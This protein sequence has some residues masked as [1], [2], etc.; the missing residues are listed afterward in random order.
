MMAVVDT[1]VGAIVSIGF[2]ILAN[3]PGEFFATN[4]QIKPAKAPL[5]LLVGA[6]DKADLFRGAVAPTIFVDSGDNSKF[7]AGANGDVVSAGPGANKEVF[8]PEDDTGTTIVV[9]PGS[10]TIIGGTSKDQLVVLVDRLWTSATGIPIAGST[11]PLSPT[12]RLTGG[13]R[14]T[15]EAITGSDGESYKI[16]NTWYGAE[17]TT[18]GVNVTYSMR[19][20]GDL[21]IDIEAEAPRY[22]GP[23]IT[24]ALANAATSSHRE[25]WTAKLL[26]KNFHPGDFGL[27]FSA[28]ASAASPD[29]GFRTAQDDGAGSPAPARAPSINDDPSVPWNGKFANGPAPFPNPSDAQLNA[30]LKALQNLYKDVPA[31]RSP[32]PVAQEISAKTDRHT[33]ITLPF[34]SNKSFS[35]AIVDGPSRGTATL[36]ADDTFTFDPGDG[37]SDLAAGASLTVTFSYQLTDIATRQRSNVATVTITVGNGATGEI[38]V[39]D[40]LRASASNQ[41]INESF[42]A[43]T[44]ANVAA[45]IDAIEAARGT[46]PIRLTD[47]ETPTLELTAK[48]AANDRYALRAITNQE[49]AI[50]VSDTAANVA[51]DLND[52]NAVRHLASISLIDGRTPTLVLTAAKTLG[53]KTALGKITNPAYAIAI[54]DRSSDIASNFEALVAND[55][56]TSISGAFGWHLTLT[57][58]ETL[59][60]ATLLATA[61]GKID[62]KDTAANV[63]AKSAL[64]AAS[65]LVASISVADAVGN[66]LSDLAALKKSSLRISISASGSAADILANAAALKGDATLIVVVDTAANVANNAKALSKIEPLPLIKVTDSAANVVKAI[67]VLNGIKQIGTITLTDPGTPT[68]TLTA[69]QLLGDRK[70]IHDIDNA[71]YDIV[72]SDIAENVSAN[73]DALNRDN[74]VASILLTDPG[75]PKLKLRVIQTLGDT[76]FRVDA[77]AKIKNPNYTVLVSDTGVAVAERIEALGRNAKISAI[78]LKDGATLMLPARDALADIK[79]LD[80]VSTPGFGIVIS[81]SVS[82][83]LANA[84]ALSSNKRLKSV[85]VTDNAANIVANYNA[86]RASPF[87]KSIIVDDNAKNILATQN[88]LVKEVNAIHIRDTVSALLADTAALQRLAAVKSV[89]VD[90]RLENVIA[91]LD[92][93]N[94]N[95]LITSIR[96][97]GRPVLELTAEQAAKN[98]RALA[99]MSEKTNIVVRDTAANFLANVDGLSTNDDISSITTTGFFQLTPTAQQALAGKRAFSKLVNSNYRI[100]VQ[101]TVANIVSYIKTHPERLSMGVSVAD[102][103]ANISA[104]LTSL[105]QHGLSSSSITAVDTAA[106]I[107]A[108]KAA[109][110]NEAGHIKIVDTAA[111]IVKNSEALN[112][113]T[114]PASVAVVDTAANVATHFEALKNNPQVAAITLTDPG[115]PIL[116]LSEKQ[117]TDDAATINNITNDKLI[118]GTAGSTHAI[119]VYGA[120][121]DLARLWRI[122]RYG[123]RFRWTGWGGST[124]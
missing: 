5:T 24:E 68:L 43:D 26:L 29:G 17:L 23:P 55:R 79:A 39:A 45:H 60:N 112:K 34:N 65:P 66:I 8:I 107:L 6:E 84:K 80:K 41:P 94:A 64:L 113:L 22:G 3:T 117:I 102:A 40:F 37:F 124:F 11:S 50:S 77:F 10:E 108:N 82:H 61:R 44:A 13:Q 97:L 57:A 103:A 70:A 106:N 114:P 81:D 36:N 7:L 78:L 32:A 85:V 67:D 30:D 2:S 18:Y 119:T 31:P 89:T 104:N 52:L 38:T 109:L 76:Y 75:T 74:Q 69:K 35:I 71:Y 59:N 62:I 90:D 122:Y 91:N 9:S 14:L 88:A 121:G 47:A 19:G 49:Y 33:A 1:L 73:F 25:L 21:Q 115:A 48:Q 83:I 12:V 51:R 99:K 63:A 54:Q 120:A 123:D 101:D 27:S 93:L 86:I 105:Q 100:V 96:V 95:T 46:P 116:K 42:V 98:S 87:V 15:A 111:N 72:I 16:K 20:D 58:D 92:S 56:V 118:L 4:S 110:A 28:P 53:D